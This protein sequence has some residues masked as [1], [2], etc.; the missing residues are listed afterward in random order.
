MRHILKILWSW[1]E[2]SWNLS[3]HTKFFTMKFI[4]LISPF[5][6]PPFIRSNLENLSKSE[7]HIFRLFFMARAILRLTKESV[8]MSITYF[9]KKLSSNGVINFLYVLHELSRSD[10]IIIAPSVSYFIFS[11]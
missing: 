11:S 4:P 6:Y 5:V 1:M 9:N 10:I 8:I 3:P 2:K 7:N